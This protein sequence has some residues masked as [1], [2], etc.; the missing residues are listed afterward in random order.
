MFS[1]DND[2]PEDPRRFRRSLVP[3]DIEDAERPPSFFKRLAGIFR[4]KRTSAPDGAE[5]PRAVPGSLSPDGSPEGI[6]PPEG[7]LPENLDP[8]PEDDGF[9]QNS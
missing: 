8:A 4:K 7:S 2:D 9:G 3:L 1:R 5:S 6:A